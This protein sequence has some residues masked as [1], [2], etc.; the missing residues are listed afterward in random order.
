MKVAIAGLGT[1][2]SGVLKCI[3]E[4]PQE[5][6]QKAGKVIT[7]HALLSRSFHKCEGIDLSGFKI[8]ENP[9]D[10]ATDEGV[11]IVVETIGGAEGTAYDLVK[12]A[13]ENKKAVVTAN[14]ALLAT[15][16]SFFAELSEK[17]ETPLY[18]EAAVAGG[19]PVIKT[20]REGLAADTVT[21][22]SGILNGTCN[23]I[24]TQMQQNV[25][26]FEEAL[27]DAQDRGYAEADPSADVDG[28]DT[29]HKLCLLTAL[30]FGVKPDLSKI[31][32]QGIREVKPVSEGS[33]KLIGHA[34]RTKDG[35]KASVKPVLVEPQDLFAQISGVTN[36]LKI[37]SKAMGETFLSGPG[38]GQA[39][40]AAA[41][42][43]DVIDL[44]QDGHRLVF[45]K[46]CVDLKDWI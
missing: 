42:V 20:L 36:A 4:K 40:T 16:G 27:S 19:V 15:H 38:A 32:V 12:T 34:M 26:S 10:C 22:V 6:A 5:I 44:A 29:A 37:K 13:L 46:P 25:V 45:A 17:H 39:P 31:D 43:A 9:L 21:E 1:I 41:I 8:Y 18:Y 24:L 2:G 33:Y 28:H 35:I 11:D 14:K 23:F 3:Q 7:V 30:A